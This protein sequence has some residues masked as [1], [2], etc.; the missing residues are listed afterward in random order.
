VLFRSLPLQRERWWSIGDTAL[1]WF[2]VG[3]RRCQ[4]GLMPMTLVEGDYRVVGASAD[5]DSVR[6]YPQDADVWGAPEPQCGPTRLPEPMRMRVAGRADHWTVGD[7]LLER[8][9]S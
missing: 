8:Q 1:E 5:G 3:S 4:S 9:P 2:V 6:F 7:P